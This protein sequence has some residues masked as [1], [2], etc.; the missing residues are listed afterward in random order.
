[1]R[2]ILSGVVGLYT[3]ASD[4]YYIFFIPTTLPTFR[5]SRLFD[6]NN[7]CN[8]RVN[9]FVVYKLFAVKGARA[10][11]S[12]IAEFRLRQRDDDSEPVR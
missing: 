12:P 9:A 11:S 2:T 8:T 5:I 4:F 7:H 3:H 6:Y 1:M 10:S